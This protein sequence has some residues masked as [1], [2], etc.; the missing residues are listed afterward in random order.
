M[1]HVKIGHISILLLTCI[2]LYGCEI[3]EAFEYS[4]SR[5]LLV[6]NGLLSPDSI[7][8]ISVTKAGTSP[9]SREQF[10]VIEQADVEILEDD[11]L[12][13]TAAYNSKSKRYDLDYHPIP[14]KSYSIA[15]HASNYPE[16]KARTNIPVSPEI[17]GCYALQTSSYCTGCRFI[18]ANIYIQN[19]VQVSKLW[20]TCF[21]EHY[22]EVPNE[23]YTI[24]I[25]ST[26][27]ER[28]SFWYLR[29]SNHLLDQFNA[30]QDRG[31]ISY[32][33]YMRFESN[34]YTPNSLEL[35]VSN[36]GENYFYNYDQIQRLDEG[37]GLYLV[38]I[39][40]SDEFDNY[41]KGIIINNF[42]D[43]DLLDD[44][45][46]PFAERVEI[47]SNIENGLG[48]FAGYNPVVIPIHETE[49]E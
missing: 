30:I 37:L 31:E 26:Q 1:I 23:D 9:I 27:T 4:S 49:C 46:N 17:T 10:E 44:F 42:N 20:F 25:D 29:S 36:G 35:E 7:I 22:K 38:A 39:T 33:V 47:Y 2:L 19:L 5:D 28:S 32:Q 21:S 3:D 14:G 41:L 15:V 24:S 6:V 45:P 40:A 13:G 16:L 8:S 43:E 18:V 12:L 34:A 48:V 11:N